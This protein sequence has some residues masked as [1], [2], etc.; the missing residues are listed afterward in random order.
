MNTSIITLRVSEELK[1]ELDMLALKE[2]RSLNN[3]LN[4]ILTKFVEEKKMKI[5]NKKGT[6]GQS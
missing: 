2:N 5:I 4:T 6:T 3:Y 1:K